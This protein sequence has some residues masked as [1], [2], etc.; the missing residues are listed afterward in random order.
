MAKRRGSLALTVPLT[1]R[2]QGQVFSPKPVAPAAKSGLRAAVS[3]TR[4][5]L[6]QLTR[7]SLQ[8]ISWQWS[9]AD[10]S[11]G[12]TRGFSFAGVGIAVL[13]VGVYL[14][15]EGGRRCGDRGHLP[16][17]TRIR[18]GRS[19]AWVWEGGDQ[20]LHSGCPRTGQVVWAAF[21]LPSVSHL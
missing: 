4:T 19:G 13:V 7:G 6:F 15:T 1:Y 11:A 14:V 21:T 16:A 2:R 18:V 20:G 9:Q 8:G 10:A 17:P 5:F 12:G 3:Q